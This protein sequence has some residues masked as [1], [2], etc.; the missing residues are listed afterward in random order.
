MAHHHARKLA[1]LLQWLAAFETSDDR[2]L[3]KG[4]IY[5]QNAE[6]GIIQHILGA[7]GT[8]AGGDGVRGGRYVEMGTQDGSECN[9]RY[10][11]TNFSWTGLMLDGGYS[12]PSIN[13]QK[14]FVTVHN[15]V[16]LLSKYGFRTPSTAS[17]GFDLLSV[18]LDCFDFWV[19]RAV[20]AAGYRPRILVNEI[21]PALQLSPPG[22]ALSV[23]HPDDP[24]AR[25]YWSGNSSTS[26]TA[27][28]TATCWGA[29]GGISSYYG[30]TVSALWKL[31]RAYNYSMVYCD[32]YGINCYGVRDDLLAVPVSDFL[33]PAMLYRRPRYTE[34]HC[35]H[36]GPAKIHGRMFVEVCSPSCD[37]NQGRQVPCRATYA[38]IASNPRRS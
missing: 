9:T 38:H 36:F 3:G 34:R 29:S 17:G 19:T 7:I 20:L 15:V 28:Y 26:A 6:D 30:A 1:A 37:E 14:E 23:P 12:D 25:H 24:R 32:Q 2:T 10:L 11:R 5:S 21:N 27:Q 35:G 18:D 8:E 33:T 4:K 22:N 16:S 31:Y 13:F